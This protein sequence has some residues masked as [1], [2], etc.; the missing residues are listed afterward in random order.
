MKKILTMAFLL[1][2]IQ[3][4]A[5]DTPIQQEVNNMQGR[6]D[7]TSLFNLKPVLNAGIYDFKAYVKEFMVLDIDKN[8]L[9]NIVNNKNQ[10][11]EIDIPFESSFITL[12][13]IRNKKINNQTNFK[14]A[15]G[16]EFYAGPEVGYYGV[17]KN[18]KNTLVAITFFEDNMMGFISNRNGNYCLGKI[19]SVKWGNNKYILYNDKRLISFIKPSCTVMQNGLDAGNGSA[20]SN[21]AVGTPAKC[22]KVRIVTDYKMFQALGSNPATVR[23]YVSGLFQMV[24]TV[25]QNES[26]NIYY[27]AMD[28]LVWDVNDPYG[29]SLY[30][31]SSQMSSSGFNGDVAHLLSGY[32]GGGAAWPNTLCGSAY[33]RTAMSVDITRY[34]SAGWMFPQTYEAKEMAHEVGHN[35]GSPHT[36]ACF[37]NDGNN[38]CRPIDGCAQPEAPQVAFGSPCT[39]CANIVPIP[40]EGGTIMSYCDATPPGVGVL[41]ANGFGTQPGNYIRAKIANASCLNNCDTDCAADVTISGTGYAGNYYNNPLTESSTWIKTNGLTKVLGGI[42]KLDANGSGYVELNPGF[43]ATYDYVSNNSLF[44]AQAFNGCTTGSPGFTARLNTNSKMPYQKDAVSSTEKNS[45]T[46]YPNPATDYFIIVSD[47]DLKNSTAELFD[48]SGKLQR[49]MIRNN[50]NNSK[51]VLVGNLSKGMYMIKIIASEK[52]EFVK[53]LVQ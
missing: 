42:V 5:Q 19:S 24:K 21:S 2:I 17:I 16:K 31:F 25:Y 11:L 37:W 43:E 39:I 28:V 51:K 34:A 49:V 29:G 53:I 50:G 13:L 9:V 23:D 36:Q 35:I 32:S 47:I 48:M 3:A 27:D 52:T 33:G 8:N 20:A 38:S 7:K 4:R 30:N 10:T 26:I 46:V 40:N 41:L 15:S 12:Q 44:T 45:F 14:T 6:F 18:Q 22:L 1:W